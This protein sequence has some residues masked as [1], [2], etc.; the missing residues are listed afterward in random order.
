MK[1]ILHIIFVMLVTLQFNGC[2]KKDEKLTWIAINVNVGVQ[3]D[4]HLIS[5]NGKHILID[6]GAW[7]VAKTHLIPALKKYGVKELDSLF[8]THPH[9]D[10]YG[11]T[12][13]ILQNGIKIKN[14]YMNMPT[15]KQMDK[16]WWG[17]KYAHLI[18]IQNAAK[19]YNIK[20]HTI[21][22]GDRISFDDESFLEVLYIYDGI[23]TPIGKTGINDM[24]AITMLYDHNN[25][26]LLT[27]DL[28]SKL[29]HYLAVNAKNIKADILKFPHHGV[30]GYA[31]DSFFDTVSPKVL[32]VPTRDSLWCSERAKR[33]REYVEKHNIP[34]YINGFH[35][36]ITVTANKQGY[37]ITTEKNPKNIC[38][39]IN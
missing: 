15:K 10:H 5:K 1:I 37:K 33:A 6:A 35:G 11:G 22:K 12:M 26:F 17:G 9:F 27:G 21:K 4:A 18:E 3:G 31:P 30:E 25:K 39:D 29:G 2:N 34:T 7:K 13:A 36:D 8:I 20:L 38:E 19:T 32:I 14:I 16:E 23:N 24:S 28:N